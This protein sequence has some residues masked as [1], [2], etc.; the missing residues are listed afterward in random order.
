MDDLLGESTLPGDDDLLGGMGTDSSVDDL[1]GGTGSDSSMDDLPGE[2][3]L[4]GDDDLPGGTDFSDTTAGL[5][6]TSLGIA[7]SRVVEE[8]EPAE[9]P[10]FN[11]KGQVGPYVYLLSIKSGNQLYFG[12][13]GRPQA[14]PLDFVVSLGFDNGEVGTE[15]VTIDGLDQRGM[16]YTRIDLSRYA[17]ELGR[18]AVAKA[19]VAL[20]S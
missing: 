9:I 4:P 18:A 2:S 13:K 14:T 15:M 6:S 12:V 1:L 20:A 17:S 11:T 3:T 16:G 7:G 19:D 5:A 10:G 8:A